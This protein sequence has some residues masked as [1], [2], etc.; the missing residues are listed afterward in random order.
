M[1]DKRA[2]IAFFCYL[3]G[4][5][6]TPS[7]ILSDGSSAAVAPAKK[8]TGNRERRITDSRL[9][10]RQHRYSHRCPTIF[11]RKSVHLIQ[12]QFAKLL[13]FSVDS[14]VN[15]EQSRRSPGGAAK[16][17]L[18]LAQRYWR[19]LMAERT[20]FEFHLLCKALPSTAVKS[21]T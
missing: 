12:R 2:E 19:N 16:T 7:M 21:T 8:R 1:N 14:I 18:S 11:A 5:R 9:L 3:T 13:N 4:I 20:G 10:L 17:F 15:W 6:S